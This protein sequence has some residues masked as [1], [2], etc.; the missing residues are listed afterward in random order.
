MKIL[1]IILSFL[2]LCCNSDSSTN[3]NKDDNIINEKIDLGE[4]KQ[5]L[6]KEEKEIAIKS[7]YLWLKYLDNENYSAAWEKS[8]FLIKESIPLNDWINTIS[9]ARGFL[10]EVVERKFK[11]S[12]Y[13]EQLPGAPDGRYVII[14]FDVVFKNKANAVETITP[15]YEDGEWKVSGYYIK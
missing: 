5:E 7:V 3:S 9:P 1:L 14:Q 15:V 11:S 2:F 4:I 6:T 8:S 13:K 12:L 10:G